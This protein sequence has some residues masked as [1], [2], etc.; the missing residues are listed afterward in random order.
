VQAPLDEAFDAAG[1][2]RPHY[3]AVM[4]ALE[5]CDLAA[6]QDGMVGEVRR[7]AMTH[8]AGA[9][10][11]PFPFDAVPR[12]LPP[13]EWEALSRGLIQRTRALDAFVA[14]AHGARTAIEAGVV[15]ADVLETCPWYERDLVGSDPPAVRVGFS[16]PDLVRD[17]AGRLVVLED[18]VRTPTML[19]Y[20]AV[21]R[22]M[23]GR[24]LPVPPP[25]GDLERT[26]R[27]AAWRVLR[28]A[29]PWTDAPEAAILGE[30]RTNALHWELD[31]LARV[32]A[33]PVLTLDELRLH[34]GRLVRATGA[35][36]I[37]VLWRRTSEERLRDD[38]GRL[39]AMG[40]ALLEPLRS[41]RLA[42]VNAFG[43]GVADDKRILP[44]VDDLIAF[45][46][47]ES[48]EL[49]AVPTYDVLDPQRRAGVLD[50][51]DELVLKPRDGC[52]GFGV[53]V[54]P[55]ATRAQLHSARRAVQAD[56]GRW[57]AQETV[58]IST[59][60]TLVGGRLEARHVD[61]RPYVIAGEDG[62]EVLPIAFCRFSP[63][64]GDMVVNCSRGGGGK[65][66]WIET[67]RPSA[68]G[69]DPGVL[70]PAA[71]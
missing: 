19:A 20:A 34:H 69:K 2:V 42:V 57:I 26:L 58:P 11:H 71:P 38:A 1:G 12:I 30:G 65:D 46:L 70:D 61:L 13:G 45:F 16:G 36:P 6:V 22:G 41:G 40:E 59:H 47:G 17:A 63:A 5:R 25:D 67:G 64:A 8:G 29:A 55:T 7:H 56:P 33:I 50:R 10:E 37:D 52:G 53:V 32:L 68:S 66:V 44:Y 24:Q 54:G 48:P 49:G 18:N 35:R 62:F 21:G 14:D 39:N 15:P 31:A 51:I 9:A 43:T 28:R 23:V 60:P 27:D 3:A 4:A